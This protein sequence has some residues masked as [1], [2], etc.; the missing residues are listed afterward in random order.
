MPDAE[1]WTIVIAILIGL[2]IA[3]SFFIKAL[4][5]PYFSLARAGWGFGG[6]CLGYIAGQIVLLIGSVLFGPFSGADDKPQGSAKVV[7][8]QTT[9]TP[10][11]PCRDRSSRKRLLGLLRV[12]RC[13]LDYP[14]RVL[15]VV[16][17]V[18]DAPA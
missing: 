12:R 11:R 16:R 9:A 15:L 17:Q 13:R 3:V 14:D 7:A 18:P 1:R 6:L 4:R 2:S 10:T 8:P 5:L